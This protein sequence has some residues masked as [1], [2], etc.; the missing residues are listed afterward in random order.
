MKVKSII[1]TIND[2]IRSIL[3]IC[4][5]FIGGCIVSLGY[6]IISVINGTD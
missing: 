3:L 2:T 6:D 5:I 1:T 4:I